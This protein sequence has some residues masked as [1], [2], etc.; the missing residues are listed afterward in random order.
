MT[1]QNN[2]KF[3]VLMELQMSMLLFWTVMPSEHMHINVCEE[4]TATLKMDVCV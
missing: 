2:M 4:Y 3:E 1:T